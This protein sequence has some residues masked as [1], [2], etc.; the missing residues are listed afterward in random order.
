MDVRA[1][2]TRLSI[3]TLLA[4]HVIV[5]VHGAVDRGRTNTLQ[6]DL[7][8]CFISVLSQ[9]YFCMRLV[10][11]AVVSCVMKGKLFNRIGRNNRPRVISKDGDGR[12]DNRIVEG[13]DH[14]EV[15]RYTE[16]APLITPSGLGRPSG[17]VEKVGTEA[18]ASKDT[19]IGAV[20]LYVVGRRDTEHILLDVVGDRV[21]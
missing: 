4:N 9:T 8:Y 11:G 15:A 14:L 12:V 16:S 6:P 5:V 10:K 3:V 19:R 2:V 1:K 20:E 17:D 13:V 7:P 21:M 18:A